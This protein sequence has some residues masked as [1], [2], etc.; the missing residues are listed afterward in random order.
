MKV[1]VDTS[2]WIDHFRA[3]KEI[4]ADLL[5]HSRV[6]IHPLVVGELACGNLENR[7][8]VI[9][10]LTDL[11]SSPVAK[12][13]EVMEFIAMRKAYG[14][15]VG[16]ADMHLLASVIL[17]PGVMLWSADKRLVRLAEDHDVSYKIH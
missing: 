11:P 8:T 10:Y 5:R 16:Y 15:G 4:L 14:K 12:H 3:E 17:A 9:G 13:D 1:L 7:S 2:V 6:L